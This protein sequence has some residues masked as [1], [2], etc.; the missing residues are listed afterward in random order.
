MGKRFVDAPQF[1]VNAVFEDSVCH[2]PILFTLA[3]GADPMADLIR[4]SDSK[5][6]G[7]RFKY[8]SL[9]QNQGPNA[10]AAVVEGMDNGTWVCLQNCHLA[11]S[12]LPELERL[13]LTLT[14]TRTHPEFRLFLT[15]MPTDAF[16][17]TVLQNSLK[18]TNEPPAGVRAKLL[19]CYSVVN[20]EWFESAG[21]P[22]A[23]KK[24]F[25]GLSL[26]HAVVQERRR[27]GS[28]GFNTPYDFN[29]SDFAVSVAQLRML[30]DEAVSRVYPSP[31]SRKKPEGGPAAIQEAV[32][33][34]VSIPFE[35]LTYLVGECNFGGRVTDSLDR[36][37]AWLTSTLL[38]DFKR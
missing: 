12:W 38:I 11:E 35:T 7:R 8:V 2:V 13:C 26:F 21:Y 18:V 4:L 9:G 16:P 15:S 29:D 25:F 23:F 33:D 17:V 30:L 19:T 3:S 6:F 34:D 5:G 32:M 24:L 1:D 14:P 36:C 37:G 28:L 20:R 27:F 10:E 22:R 31:S